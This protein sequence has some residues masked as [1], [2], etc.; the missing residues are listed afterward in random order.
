MGLWLF[1]V[2]ECIS[3]KYVNCSK[4]SKH[5]KAKHV[6]LFCQLSETFINYVFICAL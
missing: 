2:L 4:L 5:C 1:V 3:N 6:S